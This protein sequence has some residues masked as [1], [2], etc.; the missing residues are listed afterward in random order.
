MDAI[1]DNVILTC[2]QLQASSSSTSAVGEG[3]GAHRPI[4]LLD[5]ARFHPL[6]QRKRVI[7]ARVIHSITKKRSA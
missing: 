1:T 4:S 6:E 2:R 5:Y 3:V 7:S